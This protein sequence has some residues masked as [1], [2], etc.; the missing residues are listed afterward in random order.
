MRCVDAEIDG[1]L[2]QK[3]QLRPRRRWSDRTGAT[4]S[5]LGLLVAAAA[6]VL[7]S[8]HSY[9]NGCDEGP[10]AQGPHFNFRPTRIGWT[11]TFCLADCFDSGRG[12]GRLCDRSGLAQLTR[13]P[14]APFTVED[15]RIAPYQQRGCDRGSPTT[16]PAAIGAR[17]S[18]RITL[19]FSPS[20]AG[21]FRDVLVIDQKT[22]HLCGSTF[23]GTSGQG[24]AP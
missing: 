20:N 11:S 19:K 6:L 23:G 16:M 18:L 14:S 21:T 1:L 2:D 3:L 9:P 13:P 17:Q 4:R 22:V 12:P 15:Y 24:D 7:Y 8:L 10:A 5:R